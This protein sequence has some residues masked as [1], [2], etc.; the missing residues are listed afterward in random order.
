M[1]TIIS[2]IKNLFH[3]KVN[4]PR[5]LINID[6]T[7]WLKINFGYK[8]HNDSV[9]NIKKEDIGFEKTTL[10]KT[11]LQDEVSVKKYFKEISDQ[12]E[13]GSCVANAT[14]DAVEAEQARSR[15]L[16]P[17]KIRDISRLFI[18]WNA[19]NNQRPPKAHLD[20]GTYIS[21]AFDAIKR[22]GVPDET[23]WPYDITKVFHRPSPIC[24][25]K[26]YINKINNYYSINS[27]G[28]N[29][30][31]DVIKALSSGRSVVF[32]TKLNQAFKNIKG[33]Q[34]LSPPTGGFI[35]SHAMCVTGWSASEKIFEIRNSWGLD[36]GDYGYTYFTP[37][38]IKADITKDLFVATI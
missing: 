37:E 34:V 38:Y 3:P 22:Y 13:L 2:P 11:Q 23:L 14:A 35:G 4:S 18:Y 30:V 19:R 24:Y 8:E 16:S 29:R 26:G 27:Q 1:S 20:E 25:A 17:E 28:D 15:N 9:T 5:E 10:S 6:S 32:G 36:W 31:L 33:K 12:Y 7:T 21:L